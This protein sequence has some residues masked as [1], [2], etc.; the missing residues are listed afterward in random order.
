VADTFRTVGVATSCAR[1]NQAACNTIGQMFTWEGAKAVWQATTGPLVQAWRSGAA[2]DWGTAAGTLATIYFGG[3]GF[4]QRL[5]LPEHSL[6]TPRPALPAGPQRLALP[7]ASQRPALPAAPQR[8]AL[9]AGPQRVAAAL[10]PAPARQT[11]EAAPTRLAIAGAA[12]RP[13]TQ[14]GHTPTV[15]IRGDT[16]LTQARPTGTSA[17]TSTSP[18]REASRRLNI[19]NLDDLSD[20]ISYQ[21]EVSV[22]LNLDAGTFDVQLPGAVPSRP[23]YTHTNQYAVF[24]NPPPPNIVAAP[25]PLD[26]SQAFGFAF[27]GALAIAAT[28]RQKRHR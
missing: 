9:E 4:G 8:R 14:P 17:P 6:T 25:P 19:D 10:P 5:D 18:H 23:A 22:Q 2:E 21:H 7:A 24:D 11:I 3:K 1:Q 15:T 16:K 28:W 20:F 13:M 27:A 12:S 26:P